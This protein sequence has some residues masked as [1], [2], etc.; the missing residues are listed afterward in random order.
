MRHEYVAL[1]VDFH[2]RGKLFDEQVA[3]L[4]RIW[5]EPLLSIDLP[6]HRLA[7]ECIN[8]LPVQRP[9][10]VFIGGRSEAG[11]RR[12]AKIGDGW[13]GTVIPETAEP[14]LALLESELEKAGRTPAQCPVENIVI[15]GTTTGLPVRGVADAVKDVAWWKERG[16]AKTH[17]H[18]MGREMKGVTKHLAFFREVAEALGLKPS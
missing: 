13:L 11:M 8:P 16:A 9:I 14:W 15:L 3:V 5:T 7:D 18:T 4:R 17:I 12:A 10:P 6:H 1:N 2:T